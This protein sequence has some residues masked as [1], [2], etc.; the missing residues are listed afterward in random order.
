L[1]ENERQL[2]DLS[3]V[4]LCIASCVLPYCC[5]QMVDGTERQPLA[6]WDSCTY[7]CTRSGCIHLPLLPLFSSCGG[8]AHDYDNVSSAH[9][10][11]DVFSA[12]LASLEHGMADKVTGRLLGAVALDP[13]C[14]PDPDHRKHT[15]NGFDC[16]SIMPKGEPGGNPH[17][18]NGAIQPI[19]NQKALVKSMGPPISKSPRYMPPA[20]LRPDPVSEIAHAVAVST[21]SSRQPVTLPPGTES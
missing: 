7:I 13:D 8:F 10:A 21:S 16:V 1:H 2:C 19:P 18:G 12:T 5:M 9:K 3:H 11:G 15:W 17:G 20:H 6:L 14:T 4:S